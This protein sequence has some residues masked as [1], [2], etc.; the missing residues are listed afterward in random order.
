MKPIYLGDKFYKYIEEL[1][2]IE[3]VRI[4]KMKNTETF[5]IEKEE[6]KQKYKISKEKLLTE[7]TRLKPDGYISFAIANLQDNVKDVIVALY[8]RKDLDEGIQLPYAACRQNIFDLFSNQIK[9]D[10]YNQNITFIG[11]SMSVDTVPE[12]VPYEL[13][14]ACNG[15]SE[16][17][18]IATY[19]DDT[20]DILLSMVRES[21]YDLVLQTLAN[22]VTDPNVQGS[23]TTL[24]Q[25]LTENNFM[26]D[27]YR[28]FN[29]I[30]LPMEI[31]I[32]EET[33]EIIPEQRMIIEDELK[34]Q[35]F[36]T[37]ILK[38]D[39][40]IN[41]NK[42]E[43]EYIL[44]SDKNN[45]LYVLAYDKG[46]YLNRAYQQDIKDKRDILTML[47]YSKKYGI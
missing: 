41:L 27:F 17:Y 16:N 34:V 7:F 8:R 5:I 37:Y 36:R 35:M 43:R 21:K 10:N 42:I 47:K 44:L 13:I 46:E 22:N 18:M 24:R 30:K 23:C 19:I 15:L 39:K 32:I 3:I 29:I 45:N 20:L 9:R 6:T 12:N 38:Y 31:E 28:A 40:E 26:Y 1:D 2:K 4:I 14:V 33:S 25:L 11:V